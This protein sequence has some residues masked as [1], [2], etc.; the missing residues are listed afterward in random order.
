MGY[1]FDIVN[2]KC[3]K[4]PC[5]KFYEDELKKREKEIFERDYKIY[6][7]IWIG[8]FCVAVILFITTGVTLIKNK[9]KAGKSVVKNVY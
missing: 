2:Q 5:Y 3:V 8:L 9:Q 4:D 7:Y 6:L 1:Y